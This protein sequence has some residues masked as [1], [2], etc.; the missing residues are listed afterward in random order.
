MCCKNLLDYDWTTHRGTGQPQID[1]ATG[2]PMERDGP[3]PCKE[4]RR[5]HTICPK[6]SPEKEAEHLLSAKNWQTWE[7]YHAVQAS[8]GAC[9]TERMREDRLLAQNLALVHRLVATHQRREQRE[10]VFDLANV[11]LSARR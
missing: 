1:E 2:E 11:L 9:L 3:P 10:A 4:G 6:E 8:A 7:L 5:S